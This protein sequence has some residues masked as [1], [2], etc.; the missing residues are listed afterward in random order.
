MNS[1]EILVALDQIAADSGTKTKQALVGSFG[2]DEDFR[3][4]LVAALNPFN[5]YGIASIPER[6]ASS[7]G[8][9][10]FSPGTW[11]LLTRLQKR[12]LTG[13]AARAAVQGAMGELNA[14]SAQLLRRVIGKDLRA[15]FG[16]AIVNKAIPK[17][18]PEFAYMRCSLPPKVKLAE[19]PWAD[20]VF[21]QLKADG[22]FANVDAEEG[23]I[24]TIT[25]RQGSPMPLQPLGL[26]VDAMRDCLSPGYQHH[27]E[28][29]VEEFNAESGKWVVMPREKGNGRLNSVLKGG[30]MPSG[31]RVIYQVWDR[32]PLAAVV[33]KGKLKVPYRVRMEQL[34]AVLSA[35]SGSPLAGFIQLIP[36][37][38]VHSLAEAFVHYR[39]ML[40]LGL[41]GTVIK[42]PDGIWADG[43][44]LAQAKLKLDAD[45][46][47]KVVRFNPGEGKNASTFGSIACRSSCGELEVNVSGYSDP[48]RKDLH[49]RRESV[50][51][52]I[53]TTKANG[54]MYPSKAGGKHSLFLPRSV[55]FRLDKSV[56]D[57]LQRIIAQFEAAIAAV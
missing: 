33:P 26:M 9:E 48:E 46:D 41:E 47:L 14:E 36:T 1:T 25:S 34:Q 13:N 51:G 5:T 45:C 18:I 49:A 6:D 32:V 11:E 10:E 7:T 29:L 28:L 21:S 52:T 3:K 17:L 20:G 40:A 55:E 57:T 56:A 43:T 24:I 35:V 2:A 15:G 53:M 27:G 39:E 23:G 8:T 30:D 50:I 38:I 37:R 16:D 31:F 22:M 4:V 12:T 54:I 42:R 44:S 19:W